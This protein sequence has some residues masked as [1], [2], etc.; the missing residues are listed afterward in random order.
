M[1]ISACLIVRNEERFLGG[2]LESISSEVDEIVIVDTGSTDASTEIARRHAAQVIEW[3]WTDDFAAARN[4]GLDAATG[5]WILYI[6]ADER[7]SL[8]SGRRLADDLGGA[9][10]FAVLVR[11]FPSLNSTPYWEYRLFRNDPRIRFRGAMH[12]TVVPDLEA[13]RRSIGARAAKGAATLT[14]LGYE[15]DLTPKFRRNLPWLRNAVAREPD[16]VYYWLDLA[17]SLA[18]LGETEEALIVAREGFRRATERGDDRERAVGSAL[19]DVLATL[20]DE[21][22]EDSLAVIEAGLVLKPAQPRLLLL[23]A[24][25]LIAIG[26]LQEAHDILA[27]LCAVDVESMID[28]TLAYDRSL[29]NRSAPHLLGITLLRLGKPGEAAAAF[30]RAAADGPDEAG[31]ADNVAALRRA[32]LG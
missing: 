32:S 14:H 12:E 25:R 2:C 19:A 24:R 18:G 17:R 1:R 23:K 11:F 30:A 13:L 4:V 26:R 29:F 7:L 22:G 10:V 16:R 8:P 27:G 6:D 9:E 3:P 20:L 31:Y 21:R 5:D 15:G 28:A